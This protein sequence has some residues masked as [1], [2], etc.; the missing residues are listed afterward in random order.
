MNKQEEWFTLQ[1]KVPGE[2]WGDWDSEPEYGEPAARQQAL[3]SARQS[4]ILPSGTQWRMVRYKMEILNDHSGRAVTDD[5]KK[6]FLRALGDTW[7]SLPE[8]RFGQL[9]ASF[10]YAM[11]TNPDHSSVI[12]D[13]EAIS[14]LFS[15]EDDDLAHGLSLWSRHRHPGCAREAGPP[16]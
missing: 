12:R 9:L 16:S 3:S 13:R 1:A 8:L 2:G 15:I 7:E 14:R 6:E 5:Q 10:A 4:C 11:L